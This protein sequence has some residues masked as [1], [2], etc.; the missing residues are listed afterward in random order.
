MWAQTP[1]VF[2]NIHWNATAMRYLGVPL[3]NY[4]NSGPHWTSAITNIRRKVSTWHGRDLSIFSRAKACNVFL[5]SKLVYVLQV[6]H[7]SRVHIQAFHR[8]FACFIWGSSWEPM[9]RDNLFLPLEKGGLSLVHL[10]VR[11][12]V[13]RFFYLKDVCHP[14]LL[15]VL[16]NRLSYHLPFLYVTTNVAK[17]SQL[18][19]FLKEIVDTVNF[20]KTRFT[21]EY[22]YNID[23]T[24]LTAALVNSLFPEPVY[25]L[26]YLFLSGHDVLFRVRRMCISPA[27][28]TFF[29]KLHT[30]TL[31]V[32]KWLNEKAIYVPWTVNCRLCDQPETIEHC[33]IHCRDAF[34]FWDILKRTIRKDLPITAHGIRFLPFKKSPT[35]NTPYDLFMLLGL[36]ALWKSRMI[37]RHAEPPRSTRSVFREEAAQVRSVVETFEPVPEWLAL[38]DACVCLPDF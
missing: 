38:L 16:R 2:S 9:R 21:L 26:P 20:L 5:A 35:N 32:K 22:L 24:T 15:A 19:G 18:S 17:E 12:L 27:A 37:D 25:R 33:F 23:R 13:L 36:Y 1:S 10:F 8:I 3:D 7:C 28:K 4:R 29:F 34:Y 11:Q 30:S 31:P 14:F 6:L